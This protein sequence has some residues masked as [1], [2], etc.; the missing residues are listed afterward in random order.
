[1]IIKAIKSIGAKFSSIAHDVSQSEISAIPGPLAELI[2]LYLP[3]QWIKEHEKHIKAIT[4]PL[5][6]I[7][8][9][10]LPNE[11]FGKIMTQLQSDFWVSFRSECMKKMKKKGREDTRQFTAERAKELVK[12]LREKGGIIGKWIAE[13]YE[14]GTLEKKVNLFKE[15]ISGLSFEKIKETIEAAK[16]DADKEIDQLSGVEK[17]LALLK[18]EKEKFEIA[19]KARAERRKQRKE[20]KEKRRKRKEH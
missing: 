5:S 4:R 17:E 15:K 14:G 9:I 11:G 13:E 20:E 1:M 19:Q 16:L 8:N 7:I 3:K 2:V 10:L 18:L 6:I 12:T